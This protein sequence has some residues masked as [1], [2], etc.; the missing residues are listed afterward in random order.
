MTNQEKFTIF[1]QAIVVP[2][3][4]RTH[5]SPD[6]KGS[7][8]DIA[9]PAMIGPCG[10]V[11]GSGP[12]GAVKKAAADP[13]GVVLFL[14]RFRSKTQANFNPSDGWLPPVTCGIWAARFNQ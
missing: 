8:T 13:S 9:L 4:F 10:G 11:M 7:S 6:S 2:I 3:K 14:I 5:I 12:L 1:F